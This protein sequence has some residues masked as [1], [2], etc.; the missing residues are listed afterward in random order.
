M[1]E[2]LPGRTDGIVDLDARGFHLLCVNGV[3]LHKVAQGRHDGAILWRT[4]LLALRCKYFT[5]GK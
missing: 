4:D 3:A 5:Q 1:T 2:T